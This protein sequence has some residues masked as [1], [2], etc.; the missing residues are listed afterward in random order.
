MNFSRIDPN[1]LEVDDGS[2]IK[3][4]GSSVFCQGLMSGVVTACAIISKVTVNGMNGP[5]GQ[6][7]ISI[8]P[9]P[10][11]MRWDTSCWGQV[12][13]FS[14]IMGTISTLGFSFVTRGD[15]QVNKY[16]TSCEFF[17]IYLN[18]ILFVK[19]DVCSKDGPST[20]TPASSP[21]KSSS[22]Q[23][24]T[25]RSPAAPKRKMGATPMAAY[26]NFDD[27]SMLFNFIV[28]SLTD[29]SVSKFLC[30]TGGRLLAVHSLSRPPISTPFRV[31]SCTKMETPTFRT[32]RLLQ[33]GTLLVVTRA[34]MPGMS[35]IVLISSLLI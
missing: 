4:K 23:F 28:L 22:S 25:V 2:R 14:V 9:F 35:S 21:V 24:M 3:L 29:T 17:F 15:N 1:L 30:M 7:R 27:R 19:F 16:S 26:R 5:Y 11:E 33:L 34:V 8:A 12:L 20:S 31:G 6:H 10:Q 18:L 32:V 13:D